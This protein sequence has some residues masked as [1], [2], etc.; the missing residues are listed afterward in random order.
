MT[1]LKPLEQDLWTKVNNKKLHTLLRAQAL[2]ILYKIKLQSLRNNAVNN[3]GGKMKDNFSQFYDQVYKR[4]NPKGSS[5]GWIQWKGTEIC[6]DLHCICGS[7]YHFD[8]EFFYFYRC[9]N[10]KR[11]YAVGQHIKLIELS[12]EEIKL[13]SVENICEGDE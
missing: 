4:D 7:S 12:E 13:G 5:S 8:G 1:K 3:W 11:V 10:C 2:T 6:I 9:K